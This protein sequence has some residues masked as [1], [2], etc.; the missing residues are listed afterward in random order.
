MNK[1]ENSAFIPAPFFVARTPLFPVEEFFKLT[2]VP[3]VTK[4]LLHLFQNRSELREAIA[5]ASPN[6]YETLLKMIEK[7]PANLKD[8]EK[9]ISSLFKYVIRMATRATPFG[10][11]SFVSLGT[12]TETTSA[13]LDLSQV[14]K[15]ARPDM[16]WLMNEMDQIVKDPAVLGLFP[17]KRNPLLYESMGRI[18]LPSLRRSDNRQKEASIRLNPLVELI[19]SLTEKPVTQ[20]QLAQ[21]V[22]AQLHTLDHQRIIQVID[23]LIQQE[24]LHPTVFPT[25]L[26]ET[27]MQDF[28]DNLNAVLPQSVLHSRYKEISDLI[29]KFNDTPVGEGEFSLD[30]LVKAMKCEQSTIS[31]LQIDTASAEEISLSQEIASELSEGLEQFWRFSS[32]DRAVPALRPY[33]NKFLDKYGTFRLVPLLELLDETNGLGAPEEYSGATESIKKT[34]SWESWLLEQW[35][36]CIRENRAEIVLTDEIIQRFNL[37]ADFNKA[38]SSFDVF[39]EVT[40]NPSPSKPEDFKILL[41]AVSDV[42]NGTAALGRFIDLFG[43]AGKAKV[44][45]FLQDEESADLQTLYAEI[46]YFP[47]SSRSANVAIHP[48]LRLHTIDLGYGHNHQNPISIQDIFVGATQEHLYLTLKE[49]NVRLLIGANNVLDFSTAPILVRFLRD[50]S[51]DNIRPFSFFSWG[52]GDAF[53][54]LPSIRYKKMVWF[55]ARWQLTLSLIG[56]TEKESIEV[57]TKKIQQWADEWK[58]PRFL[59]MT[60]ADHQILLDRTHAFHLKEIAHCLKTKPKEPVILVEKK[61]GEE[62]VK[63]TQGSHR[64]EFVVPFLKN[65][66]YVSPWKYSGSTSTY[67]PSMRWKIPGG[68]WLYLKI[69]L[70]R[71]NEAR[72]LIS[73]LEPFVETV[74]PNIEKWFF[75]RYKAKDASHIRLRLKITEASAFGICLEHLHNWTADLM[76]KGWIK[77]VEL[78]SYEREIERYG[79]PQLIDLMETFFQIDSEMVCSILQLSLS[80]KIAFPEYIVA[81]VSLIDLLINFGLSLEAQQTLFSQMNLNDESLQGFREWKPKLVPAISHLFNRDLSTSNAPAEF[82]ALFDVL[83]AR[84]EHFTYSSVLINH[85]NAPS[86]FHSLMHMHCNRLLGIDH[87]ME[88]KVYSYCQNALTIMSKHVGLLL[89]SK[90]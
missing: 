31:K 76:Q 16:E 54:F 72:F 61:E 53:P 13:T 70:P 55:T 15:R 7:A 36:L 49:G 85:P 75:I 82:E 19:L 9:A 35:I 90:Q 18:Y 74:K 46:S 43:D 2:T 84:R 26:T 60:W 65:K 68:E 11:F 44:R 25:L 14:K 39:F 83:T 88:Q 10:L 20:E 63:S 27:P 42:S 22:V 4:Y 71:S 80:K 30:N 78:A 6:L 86:I 34:L 66:K 77:E 56:A 89:G 33:F 37:N 81:A 40:K 58:L 23:S 24:F 79:G 87:Q 51:R 38:P 5:V 8:T 52:K 50:V 48:N 57:L 29:E 47:A 32:M 21:Q 28:I 12:W 3:D 67:E 41:K 59:L 17:I 1:L 45:S 64:S 69:Y 73:C 62:L